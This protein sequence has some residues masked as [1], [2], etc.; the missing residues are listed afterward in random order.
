MS[1]S[2]DLYRF[3]DRAYAWG[4]RAGLLIVLAAKVGPVIA[5]RL[6]RGGRS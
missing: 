6:I 5:W 2:F 3:E 1:R 4:F